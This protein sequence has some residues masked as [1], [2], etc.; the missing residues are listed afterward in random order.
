MVGVTARQLPHGA[1]ADLRAW[2]ADDDAAVMARFKRE[3]AV[4]LARDLGRSLGAVYHR[5]KRIGAES[6]K[7]R[8]TK[9]EDA[10]LT[11]MWYE[12]GV[13]A[14]ATR[15]KRSQLS[16]YLSLVEDDR[17]EE[18]REAE[19]PEE[20]EEMRAERLAREAEDA[21]HGPTWEDVKAASKAEQERAELAKL[22]EEQ[23]ADDAKTKRGFKRGLKVPANAPKR[24]GAKREVH[25]DNANGVDTTPPEDGLAF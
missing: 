12:A 3:G 19:T 21:E 4:A 8:W 10:S 5:A 11:M 20:A 1:T 24:K 13:S 23:A 14:I 25:D 7:R 17:E 9:A 2:S 18:Q 6:P 16:V 15:L 22:V